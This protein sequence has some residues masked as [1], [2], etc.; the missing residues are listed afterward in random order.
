MRIKIDKEIDT[1]FL[2]LLFL[3]ILLSFF[4]EGIR[5]PIISYLRNEKSI[6]AYH[7]TL[8]AAIIATCIGY[9]SIRAVRDQ[10][11]DA[12][13][14]RIDYSYDNARVFLGVL[15][16]FYTRYSRAINIAVGFNNKHETGKFY[17]PEFAHGMILDSSARDFLKGS[18][19]LQNLPEGTIGDF[20]QLRLD[21]L[22]LEDI[23]DGIRFAIK[24]P[25]HDFSSDIDNINK[26][27]DT[28]NIKCTEIGVSISALRLKHPVLEK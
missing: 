3:V 27:I 17:I 10:I 11:A 13:Q 8:I 12:R 4:I 16:S 5:E 15:E 18:S 1:P 23:V 2:V 20:I 7:G 6:L 24:Y 19:C 9:Y 28:I 14:A 22:R 25:D 26:I 21:V